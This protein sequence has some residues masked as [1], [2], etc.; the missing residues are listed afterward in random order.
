M[1]VSPNVI[2]IIEIFVTLL[3]LQGFDGS[4]RL[5]RLEMRLE[6]PGNV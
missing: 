4:Y 5:F 1:F 2:Q 6:L 3:G